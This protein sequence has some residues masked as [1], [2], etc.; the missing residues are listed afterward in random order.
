MT[1]LIALFGLADI[2]CDVCGRAQAAHLSGGYFGMPV[3]LLCDAC[4]ADDGEGDPS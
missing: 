1:D 2:R 3:E 4:D